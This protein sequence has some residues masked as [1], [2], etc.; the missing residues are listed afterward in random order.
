MSLEENGSDSRRKLKE[1]LT[2]LRIMDSRDIFEFFSETGHLPI[3]RSPFFDSRQA[4]VDIDFGSV[5]G[6]MLG[7]AIGDALGA[8]TEGMF[9]EERRS[10]FG[11]IEDYQPNRDDGREVGIPTDDSQLAFWTV[12]QLLEDES[13]EPDH[14]ARRFCR[15]RLYGAG[16]SVREFIENYSENDQ[17]WFVAG[18]V[19]AGNGA[20]MRIPGIILPYIDAPDGLWVD[21]AL[22][23]MITH[24]DSASVASCVAFTQ[25]CWEVLQRDVPPDPHWWVETFLCCS[26]GL[27]TDRS[28]RPR[29]P[30]IPIDFQGTVSKFVNQHV[31]SAFQ[32]D[33]TVMEVSNYWYS[34]AY[35]LETVPT[36]MYIL[37][38]HGEDPEE[39]V[40]RA[41]T[42][43]KDNDTIAAIVGAA[44]GAMHGVDGLP[45]RWI[46]GLT[47]RT[48]ASD[49]G[50]MFDL[51]DAA[52]Q[53]WG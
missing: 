2:L 8:P 32:E 13:F 30:S 37:M 16:G 46:R 19:S 7:L 9:P 14:L 52:E 38:R 53:Q 48:Q 44:V 26:R 35:L 49:D 33:R 24:R 22:S 3:N 36:A 41:V 27:E 4:A 31:A 18:A 23:A 47:G 25:L 6:M 5:R 51:L 43:T 42:D 28:H 50:R 11:D 45:D 21:T 34:G 10:R 20:L 40:V 1:S 17:A 39:A 15:G 29:D 12:E